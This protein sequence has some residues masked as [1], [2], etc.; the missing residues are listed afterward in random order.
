MGHQCAHLFVVPCTGGCGG[1]CGGWE[2]VDRSRADVVEF[3][4][5]QPVA[6]GRN[7]GVIPATPWQQSASGPAVPRL[8]RPGRVSY[9]PSSLGKLECW[10]TPLSPCCPQV[11]CYC[12]KGALEAWSNEQRLRA[13]SSQAV[14]SGALSARH[15][16]VLRYPWALGTCSR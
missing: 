8:R 3:S 2:G 4:Q 15:G 10:R 13:V 5:G 7:C 6:Y 11:R 12:G 14:R 1:E 9:L 16:D